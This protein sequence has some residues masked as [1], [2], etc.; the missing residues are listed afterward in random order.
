MALCLAESLIECLGFDPADQM[1]RYVRWLR[2][3]HLS[4]AGWCFDIGD[5]TYGALLRFLDDAAAGLGG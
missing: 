3:G 5:T 2:R 4:S 1:E